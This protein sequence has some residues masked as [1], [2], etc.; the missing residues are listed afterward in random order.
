MNRTGILVEPHGLRLLRQN[1]SATK[2]KQPWPLLSLRRHL[3][4][5]LAKEDTRYAYLHGLPA[6]AS[7]EGG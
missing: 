3:A 5:A 1:S 2:A 6:V 4:E 7:C